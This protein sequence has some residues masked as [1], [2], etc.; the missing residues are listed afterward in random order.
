MKKF[1]KGLIYTIVSLISLGT[2]GAAV[3]LSFGASDN[4]KGQD[5]ANG[6]NGDDGDTV[7]PD[8]D[9]DDTEENGFSKMVNS[10]LA[11]K[12]LKFDNLAVSLDTDTTN[13]INLSL[14]NL[15]IDLTDSSS[16]DL[17][18]STDLTLS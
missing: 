16:L 15:K 17:N 2:S 3:Y 11:S 10:L 14:N 9:G 7:Y 6:N 12:E 5:N 4:S 13:P 18:F 8:M 1:K